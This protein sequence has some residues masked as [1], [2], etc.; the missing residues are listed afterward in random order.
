MIPLVVLARVARSFV[1]CGVLVALLTTAVAPALAGA[2]CF[3]GPACC[4]CAEGATPEAPTLDA[5]CCCA[6]RA[7]EGPLPP[8]PAAT[9]TDASATDI[10]APLASALDAAFPTTLVPVPAEAR[11]TGPDPPPLWLLTSTVRR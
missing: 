1:A 6:I 11:P 5:S 9:P 10:A 7:P 2:R 8:A 3:V 4:P